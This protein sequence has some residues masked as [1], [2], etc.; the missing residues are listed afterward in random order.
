VSDVHAVVP[1]TRVI[2]SSAV[3]G[4]G[5]DEIRSHAATGLTACLLGSSGVGKS[6]LINRLLGEERQAVQALREDDSRGRHTTSRR[7]LFVLPEGGIVIDTPGLRAVGITGDGDA[8]EASFEDITALARTC[9]FADCS[10]EGEP[11]CAVQ[12]AVERGAIPAERVAS[13]HRLEA[14]RRGA[15]V[16][17]HVRER[18]EAERRIGRLYRRA[19][20]DAE[21]YKRGGA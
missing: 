19:G 12:A 16:R 8:L 5:V 6:S 17:A 1:G 2:I 3:T 10:H 20:R 18:R 7:E 14:E 21:R 4:V 13:H 15:E 9:R 11:G